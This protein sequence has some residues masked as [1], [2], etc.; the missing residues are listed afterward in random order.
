MEKPNKAA[1]IYRENPDCSVQFIELCLPANE[2]KD[3]C[4]KNYKFEQTELYQLKVLHKIFEKAMNEKDPKV[5]STFVNVWL[6]LFNIMVNKKSSICMERVKILQNWLQQDT[7]M[8]WQIINHAHWESFYRTCLK[9]GLKV[10][11]ED[12]SALLLLLGNI[13]DQMYEDNS[14]SEEAAQIF[15][16]IFTHSKFFEVIFNFKSK[17]QAKYHVFFLLHALVKK[18]HSVR[19]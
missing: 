19:I 18:N 12:Q 17:S 4:L 7:K 9:Y 5:F 13:I 6:Q 16:M 15:D 10:Q 14:N 11:D 3:L 1:Q 2:C 8:D